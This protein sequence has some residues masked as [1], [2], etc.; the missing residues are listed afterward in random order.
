[1]ALKGKLMLRNAHFNGRLKIQSLLKIG[2]NISQQTKTDPT[3]NA[4]SFDPEVAGNELSRD[5]LIIFLQAAC[6]NCHY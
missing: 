3:Q 6:Y 2:S 4:C 1:M 5:V